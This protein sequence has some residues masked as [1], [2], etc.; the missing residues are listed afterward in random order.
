MAFTATAN[1]TKRFANISATPATFNLR[2]GLYGITANATWSFGSLTLQRLSKD[3]STWITVL[4]PI[5]ETG[6]TSANLPPGAY[7]LLV[8][9][10]TA[11]YVEIIQIAAGV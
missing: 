7:R 8:A 11:L 1:E 4:S 2:G 6:Y 3:G 5:T 10:A 9:T